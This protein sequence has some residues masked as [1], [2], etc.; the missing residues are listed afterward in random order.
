[1]DFILKSELLSNLFFATVISFIFV[2]QIVSWR[3]KRK[4]LPWAK[5]VYQVF[6]TSGPLE[7]EIN[8]REWRNSDFAQVYR[9]HNLYVSVVYIQLAANPYDEILNI[10]LT[11]KEKSGGLIIYFKDNVPMTWQRVSAKNLHNV[12]EVEALWYKKL[13]IE[14]KKRLP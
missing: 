6:T 8:P 12:M 11:T 5:D 2:A 9:L 7:S 13:I 14:V 10:Q 1:M 3:N 4:K